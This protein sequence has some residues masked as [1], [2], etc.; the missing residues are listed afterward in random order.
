MPITTTLS[1]ARKLLDQVRDKIRFKH[2]SLSTENT[3]VSWIKQYISFNGKRYP[4]EM[5]AAEVEAF[6]T[7][8]ATERHVSSSTQSRALSAILFLYRCIVTLE[9]DRHW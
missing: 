4:A 7:Y 6:L 3:Y 5:G 9:T 8:L 2:Y 1:P